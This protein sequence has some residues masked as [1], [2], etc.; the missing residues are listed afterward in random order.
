MY[1][2][3]NKA[4]IS[5]FSFLLFFSFTAD[6][7]YK[8]SYRSSYKS[9]SSSSSTRSSFKSPSSSSRPS[10]SS[11]SSSGSSSTS[12]PASS[13]VG[14]SNT[15]K[16]TGTAG[17]A[18]TSTTKSGSDSSTSSKTKSKAY[19]SGSSLASKKGTI[20]TTS[21]QPTK[22]TAAS[23]PSSK[24]PGYDKRNYNWYSNAAPSENMRTIIRERSGTDWTTLAL[25]YWMLS[26]NNSHASSLSSDDRSWIKQQIRDEESHGANRD[27]A[28]KELKA[29]GVD[30][31]GLDKDAQKPTP[32][33]E[34]VFDSPKVMTAG[35]VWMFTVIAKKDGKVEVPVC[36]LAGAETKTINEML[37][38][39]WKAPDKAGVKSVIHCKAFGEEKN[40][41]LETV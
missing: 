29:S 26:S 34:F 25:M 5:F 22:G 1:R 11:T 32:Q 19:V 8:S 39:K 6:A 18:P 31:A 9:F 2:L 15:L 36:T 20:P 38:V 27:E 14:S 10:Y 41:T 16:Q 3:L 4:V 28:L 35:K 13:S 7:G 21:K 23:P 12:K 33:V 40:E 17:S 37:F 24:I 30:I